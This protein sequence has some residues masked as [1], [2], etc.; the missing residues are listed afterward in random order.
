MDTGD[1]QGILGKHAYQHASHCVIGALSN[2]G[3]LHPSVPHS[4]VVSCQLECV[5]CICMI[6]KLRC[7]H[8]DC[9]RLVAD[10]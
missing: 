2:W 9:R 7:T 10:M 1:L 4:L 6:M 3:W 8:R 5:C